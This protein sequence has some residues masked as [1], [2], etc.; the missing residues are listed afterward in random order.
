MMNDYISGLYAP[1]VDFA[2]KNDKQGHVYLN[3]VCL[4]LLTGS[5]PI[6]DMD[7]AMQSAKLNLIYYCENYDIN[8]AAINCVKRFYNI[9]R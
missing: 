2:M 1:L 8:S 6:N 4:V 9:K 3:A 7:T 5:N